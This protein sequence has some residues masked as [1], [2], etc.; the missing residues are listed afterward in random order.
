VKRTGNLLDQV[1]SYHNL[2]SAF[3]QA[4][5][6]CG[7]TREV[8]EFFYNLEE[9]IFHL[10]DALQ[11]NSYRPGRYRFF[12]IHDPKERIIAVAPFKDRVVHHGLVN[13]LE[14]IFEPVFIYDSYATRKEKGTHKAILR[15]QKF[16]GTW[17]WY[18]KMD[19]EKYFDNVDHTSILSLLV[20]KIKDQLL[21]ALLERVIGNTPVE[22]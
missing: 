9:E 15:A 13:V 7:K 18:L 1:A 5:K 4:M 2:I 22:T 10:Q 8:C 3:Y 6:G 20:R 12:T 14:K 16:V 17:S 19:I 21:I 11:N